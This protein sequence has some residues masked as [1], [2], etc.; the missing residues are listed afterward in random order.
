MIMADTASSD[1]LFFG[2]SRQANRAYRSIL[3]GDEDDRVDKLLPQSKL[4]SVAEHQPWAIEYIK[5]VVP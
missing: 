3:D 1:Y 2:A 5:I 4:N